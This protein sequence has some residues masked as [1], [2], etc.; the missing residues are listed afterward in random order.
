[1]HNVKLHFEEKKCLCIFLYIDLFFLNMSRNI[2]P[3]SSE[4][5]FSPRFVCVHQIKTYL[6]WFPLH[7]LKN[8][9]ESIQK[10]QRWPDW[11]MVRY[12]NIATQ[13]SI[14]SYLWLLWIFTGVGWSVFPHPPSWKW[15][16]CFVVSVVELVIWVWANVWCVLEPWLLR[17]IALPLRPR[18]SW[19]TSPVFVS[20]RLLAGTFPGSTGT[21]VAV[22]VWH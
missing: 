5:F 19:H 16:Q 15:R 10:W 17:V 7:C 1:M 13:I 4:S 21:S 20:D 12:I 18:E 14:C 6:K 22:L 9:N 3:A 11:S 2:L 8:K